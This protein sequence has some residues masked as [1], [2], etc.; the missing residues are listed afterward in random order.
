MK[1]V[2]RLLRLSLAAAFLL[3]AN[4]LA[5][6]PAAQPTCSAVSPVHTVALVELYTSEGCSSC[7]PADRWLSGMASA[8]ANANRLI[9]LGL[10][11]DYWDYIGWKDEFAS[12][13]FTQRQRD[14]SQAHR[15]RFVYTPQIVLSGTDYRGWGETRFEAD[16]RRI[17]GQTARAALN[18]TAMPT[19]NA[20][21]VAAT[22]KIADPAHR[23]DAQVYFALTQDK[24][25]TVVK[26]GENKGV[27]LKHDHVVRDWHGPFAVLP[28]GTVAFEKRLAIPK[29]A[30]LADLRLVMFAQRGGEILQAVSLPLAQSG[31]S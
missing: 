13:A 31:C 27:T 19:K 23:R 16:L 22:A 30:P 7:P 29:N 28:D 8:P 24:V 4:Q 25:S 17:N 1:P 9:G 10:H 2:T 21:A 15:S 12:A 5:A 14:W 18:L 20:L 6:Q 3:A 26:R 11:V